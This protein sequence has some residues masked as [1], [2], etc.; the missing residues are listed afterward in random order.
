VFDQPDATEVRAQCDRVVAGLE[1]KF[2]RAAEH[3]ADAGRTCWPSPRSLARSGGRSG[4]TTRESASTR[5]SGAAPTLSGSSPTRASALRLVGAVLLE[6]T[7]EW[8]AQRR[9]IGLELLT[10]CDRATATPTTTVE[11]VTAMAIAA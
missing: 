4:R 7:G 3:L 11:E 5:R 10:R 8:T 2:P 9:Y 1:A 6:Q